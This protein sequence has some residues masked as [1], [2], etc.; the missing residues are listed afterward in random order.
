[1]QLRTAEPIWFMFFQLY[2]FA[3]R[4]FVRKTILNIPSWNIGKF[5][6]YKMS[7]FILLCLQSI[8]MM[9]CQE[10]VYKK[11]K[12]KNASIVLIFYPAFKYYE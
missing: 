2:V 4:R 5:K 3:K 9:N 10:K 6:I 12:I 1:M 7:S 11:K 8:T